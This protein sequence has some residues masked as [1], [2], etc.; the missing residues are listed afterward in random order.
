MGPLDEAAEVKDDW[1]VQLVGAGVE[2]ISDADWKAQ[3]AETLRHFRAWVQ[4]DSSQL[5]N[6]RPFLHVVQLR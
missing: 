3:E 2:D 1:D 4:I 5:L 6:T